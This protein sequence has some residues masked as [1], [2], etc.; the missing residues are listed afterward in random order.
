MSAASFDARSLQTLSREAPP[1]PPGYLPPPLDPTGVTLET[2]RLAEGVYALVANTLFTDNSGFVV[3]RDAVL[4]V[5]SQFNGRMGQQVIDAVRRVTDKPIRYLVNTNAFGDHTL[6]NYVFPP[7]TQIV[8]AR[9]TVTAL[10]ATN[11]AEI[12]RRMASTVGND[13]HVFDGVELRVP[14]VAFDDAWSTDL[15]GM[16][17]EVRFF[18]PGM[19]PNDTVVYVPSARVAWTGN[20][21]FG[22]GTIPWAQS[23]GI[24]AYQQTIDRLARTFDIATIVPGHAALTTGE[25]LTRYQQYLAA[26]RREA[27]TAVGKGVT[28]ADFAAAAQIPAEYQVAAPLLPLMTGFHRWNLQRAYIEASP[29]K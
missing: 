29:A 22:A 21:V 15:G 11:A 24:A 9:S 28:M 19:S 1:P 8:A 26:I 13:P 27:S 2:R 5:D 7:S 18:G 17:V 4:V 20:L 10:R 6:G 3:G 16:R 23:G 25:I 14:D 12:G